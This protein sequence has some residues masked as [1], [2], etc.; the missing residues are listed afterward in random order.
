MKRGPA[1][2]DKYLDW[3][4]QQPCVVTAFQQDWGYPI[5]AHHVTIGSGRGLGQKPSDYRSIPL[6][7]IEHDRL[8][9]MGE[10]AY[11]E[12]QGE[13]PHQLITSLMVAYLIENG[14]SQQLIV[15]HLEHLMETTR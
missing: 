9:A 15:E 6:Y 2:D 3:V 4:R 12:A 14:V 5:H 7:S 11:W 13:D 10:R 1:R 8:H